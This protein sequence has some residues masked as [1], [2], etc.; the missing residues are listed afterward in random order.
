MMWEARTFTPRQKNLW[1]KNVSPTSDDLSE[2]EFSFDEFSAEATPKASTPAPGNMAQTAQRN[3]TQKTLTPAIIAKIQAIDNKSDFSTDQQ[4]LENTRISHQGL[5][6]ASRHETSDLKLPA[7]DELNGKNHIGNSDRCKVRDV[8]IIKNSASPLGFFIRQGDGSFTKNGIF[9]SRVA[10]GSFVDVNGLLEVGDEII[11]VNQVDIDGF[12]VDDVVRMIQI[13]HKLILTIRTS[14]LLTDRNLYSEEINGSIATSK[15]PHETTSKAFKIKTK[16]SRSEPS[17]EGKQTIQTET[18]NFEGDKNANHQKIS[19]LQIGGDSSTIEKLIK[20]IRAQNNRLKTAKKNS[21]RREEEG[22]PS[23]E[24]QGNSASSLL[25]QRDIN[26][27]EAPTRKPSADS[28]ILSKRTAPPL[29][30]RKSSTLTPVTSVNLIFD[31]L[32]DFAVPS[33]VGNKSMSDEDSLKAYTPSQ[34]PQ[35]PPSSPGESPKARRRLPSVPSDGGRTSRCNSDSRSEGNSPTLSKPLLS[36]P[37]EPR[38][39]RLLPTPP[40]SPVA[41]HKDALTGRKSSSSSIFDSPKDGKS[42]RNSWSGSTDGETT[43]EKSPTPRTPSPSRKDSGLSL[44]QIFSAFAFKSHS[45][46]A[47]TGDK[48][49]DDQRSE[50]Y[51]APTSPRRPARKSESQCQ[52]ITE[53]ERHSIVLNSIVSGGLQVPT[54]PRRLTSRSSHPNLKLLNP[55]PE[56]GAKSKLSIGSASP[57]GHFKRSPFIRRRASLQSMTE[58]SLTNQLASQD[59]TDS[60]QLR[61][62]VDVGFLIFPDDYSGHNLLSS[63]AVSG[64]VSLHV[65]RATNLPFADK[66]L[67][68]KKKKVYCAVEVDFERK[69]FTSSK[70]ASKSIAWDEVFDV[71]VQHGREICLSCFTPGHEFDKP[72]AKVSFNLSPFVR[73]GQQHSTV[74][75]LHPQGAIHLKMEFTEMKALLKRAHS[76]RSSGV[77]GFQLN[78]TSR[79]EKASVPL[80]V[81]KCVEEIEKR[82]LSNV[83]LYRI[84]GNARRKKQLHAQ[85]D[86]DSTTVNLSEENYPDINVIAGILKDYLR[87]LPEPLITE[88]LSKMLIKAAKEQVQDQDLAAQKRVLSK[89]LVQLPQ[90]NRETLVYLLNH[91]LRVTAQKETNKMDAHNLSVCFGPVLLCPPANLTESKDLLDLKLHNRIVE[92]LLFLWNSTGGISE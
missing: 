41:S 92:F 10:Q 61:S 63:H 1:S 4:E 13:P 11:S 32:D 91:F 52:D 25:K 18:A 51:K 85:F 39:R 62:E 86:E 90:H 28:I 53:Q 78:V 29:P 59:L 75:R 6:I 68:E 44:S 83:G 38:N 60:Y 31:D 64:M 30:N 33:P 15:N 34:T 22:R 72:V 5:D 67:L 54:G 17:N 47:E 42:N 16:D 69:A 80:I 87:E 27:P 37:S 7:S 50:S 20:A 36:L 56:E 35:S 12:H 77:F 23:T 2:I 45:D 73:C 70:R 55:V 65:I 49:K 76:D 21:E 26:K 84:S 79:N 57:S 71:E 88:S 24:D 8:V 58:N 82:G 3:V 14:D 48:N 66:K 81:R 43:A 89:L 9:V 19:R 46:G 40:S 74:F